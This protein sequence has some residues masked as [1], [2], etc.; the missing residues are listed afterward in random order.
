M[1]IVVLTGA[2]GS[3]KTAIADAIG[4][5][6]AAAVEVYHFDH[7]G[8]PP[9]EQIV[10]EHG[11]GEA[12]QR[13]MTFNWMTKLAERLHPGARILFEGQMRLSFVREA[14]DAA[15]IKD[16]IVMLVDCDDVTR[17]RR[18]TEDRSSPDLANATMM[19][20]AKYL[21]EEAKQFHCMI[22]DTTRMPLEMSAQRVWEQLHHY[23]AARV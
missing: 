1:P 10:R 14:A 17:T 6:Y 8:I 11:S 22:L 4:S 9:V 19:S 3:G 13:A 15:G 18:L 20:W 16:Y 23:P 12:W 2:S 5:R 7:S 21:R